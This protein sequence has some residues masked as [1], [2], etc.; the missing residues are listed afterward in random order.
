MKTLT[1]LALIGALTLGAV[2]CVNKDSIYNFDGTIGN[3]KIK[4][5]TY[6]VLG[7]CRQDKVQILQSDG[8]TINYTV[9]YHFLGSPSTIAKLKVNGKKIKE[10]GF[11]E[12]IQ[13][14]LLKVDSEYKD[15]ILEAKAEETRHLLE[16]L[17]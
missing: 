17:K 4:S 15:K 6:D 11:F 5:T 12:F 2:G 8:D 14:S 7:L 16:E 3:E 1:K 13:D 10:D 9:E